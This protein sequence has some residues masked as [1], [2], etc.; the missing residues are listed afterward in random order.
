YD[1]GVDLPPYSDT[2]EEFH[3]SYRYGEAVPYPVAW[4]E[5]LKVECE[6]F[7]QCIR[8]GKE[9]RSSGEVGLRVVRALNAAQRSLLNGQ[10]WEEIEC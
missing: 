2:E 4:A 5:P 6:H 7:L 1:K 9:P 3:L 10:V 8:E